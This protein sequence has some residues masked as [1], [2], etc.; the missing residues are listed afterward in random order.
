MNG[1]WVSS[2]D[3]SLADWKEAF[4]TSVGAFVQISY[5]EAVVTF[6]SARSFEG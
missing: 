5:P 3:Y 2:W 4:W 1:A 6:G